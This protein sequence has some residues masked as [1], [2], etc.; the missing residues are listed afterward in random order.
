MKKYYW[1]VLHCG[2]SAGGVVMAENAKV[3]YAEISEFL[4]SA[5]IRHCMADIR[6]LYIGTDKNYSWAD[7]KAKANSRKRHRKGIYE[8][9]AETGF[10]K[11]IPLH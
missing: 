8:M 9:M 3:A 10:Y 2:G 1:M 4:R 11:P 6:E 7:L 5:E